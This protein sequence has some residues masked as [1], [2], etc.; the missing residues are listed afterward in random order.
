MKRATIEVTED[1]VQLLLHTLHR[2]SVM[3]SGRNYLDALERFITR[4]QRAVAEAK[5]G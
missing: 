5:N 4:V 3:R 1:D 2:K